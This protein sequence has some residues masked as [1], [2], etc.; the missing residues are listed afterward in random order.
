MLGMGH[1]ARTYSV[2]Y[3]IY[4]ATPRFSE[5]EL[6]WEDRKEIQN[7][8]GRCMFSSESILKFSFRFF[9]ISVTVTMEYP[10]TNLS[11]SYL[12]IIKLGKVLLF[13]YIV[14]LYG[15]E[16]LRQWWQTF[17]RCTQPP[18]PHSKG[19]HCKF[20]HSPPMALHSNLCPYLL[21]EPAPDKYNK[22]T[23]FQVYAV[24]DLMQFSTG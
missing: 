13:G 16:M 4:R 10:C 2:M 15:K 12:I 7:L 19:A 22:I 1:L 21:F 23:I 5:F 11:Q 14:E 24:G 18:V 6:G 20:T 17:L 8:Y 3:A 9:R